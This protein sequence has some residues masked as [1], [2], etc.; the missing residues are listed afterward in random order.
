MDTQI[1]A[2]RLLMYRAAWMKDV[3]KRTTKESS[4]AKLYAS[5]ISVK[6]CEEAIQIHGGY[7]YTKDCPPEKYWRDSKRCTIGEGTSELQRI[8]IAREVLRQVSTIAKLPISECRFWQGWRCFE[9]GIGNRQLAMNNLSVR[10]SRGEPAAVARAISKIE[11][12]SAGAAALM[13]QIYQLSR[14][15]L[16]LGITG[17][18]GAGKS[19]LVDK[20]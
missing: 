3:G 4:M 11:D 14:G 1:D 5:E 12:G 9:L 13:K 8:I 7:G 6:V 19:S 18:P 10:V 15:A 20:L 17:A 16:V 2:A